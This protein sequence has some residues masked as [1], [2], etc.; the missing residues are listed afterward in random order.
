MKFAKFE[1]AKL[2]DSSTRKQDETEDF[3]QHP[4]VS[5]FHHHAVKGM[6]SGQFLPYQSSQHMHQSDED[7]LSDA[8]STRKEHNSLTIPDNLMMAH[9]SNDRKSNIENE[10]YSQLVQAVSNGRSELA[11]FSLKHNSGE[12]YY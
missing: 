10:L 2:N 5:S 6:S 3:P 4:E 11:Q 9:N 1:D 7:E 8:V 12:T